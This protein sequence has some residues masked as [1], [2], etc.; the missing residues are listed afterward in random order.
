M[1]AQHF[2]KMNFYF[3]CYC[4][5]ESYALLLQVKKEPCG[6]LDLSLQW[7]H[8]YRT[9]T[10]PLI[11]TQSHTPTHHTPVHI[12]Q[13]PCKETPKEP[14]V[15][16]EESLPNEQVENHSSPTENKQPSPPNVES[17]NKEVIDKEV[18]DT[19]NS[20]VIDKDSKTAS[21]ST[22][23]PVTVSHSKAPSKQQSAKQSSKSWLKL[24]KGGGKDTK[25][26]PALSNSLP[27]L[28]H[29][30]PPTQTEP[31]ATIE[32]TPELEAVKV[33][34][35]EAKPQE[36]I[37]LDLPPVVEAGPHETEPTSD[38]DHFSITET[39]SLMSSLTGLESTDTQPIPSPG[40]SAASSRLSLTHS[41]DTLVPSPSPVVVDKQFDNSFDNEEIEEVLSESGEDTMFEDPLHQSSGTLN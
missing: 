17:A 34:D 39:E 40:V 25:A 27:P 10:P 6:Y 5:V 13:P 36:P 21:A 11:V 2:L 38:G 23:K 18:L 19:H 1:I 26:L 14:F 30:P 20:E 41:N 3:N 24:T 15:T 35:S 31:P 37:S 4:T 28:T 12:V 8:T 16:K 9:P 33:N 29:A 7:N 32:T 22:K